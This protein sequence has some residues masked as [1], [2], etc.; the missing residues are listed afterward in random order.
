MVKLTAFILKLNLF[1]LLC[2]QKVLGIATSI[3]GFY[4]IIFMGF[5][6]V[7]AFVH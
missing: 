4:A 5:E 2:L 1:N 3:Q 7:L 6:A